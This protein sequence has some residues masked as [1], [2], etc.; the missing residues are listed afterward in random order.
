[1][2]AEEANSYLQDVGPDDPAV[3][4]NHV[5]VIKFEMTVIAA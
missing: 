4:K 2:L 1:M 5:D 3:L